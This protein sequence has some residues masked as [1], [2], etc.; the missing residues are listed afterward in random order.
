MTGN[1]HKE[2]G[3]KLSLIL[4]RE[5]G[6]YI[7][8]TDCS[9]QMVIAFTIKQIKLF[10]GKPIFVVVLPFSY[11]YL[12]CSVGLVSG[13]ATKEVLA[14]SIFSFINCCSYDFMLI[15]S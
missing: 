13:I 10:N 4:V 12:W 15:F 11:L 8:K 9:G 2:S 3:H 1:A 7:N 5:K 14:L 6:L